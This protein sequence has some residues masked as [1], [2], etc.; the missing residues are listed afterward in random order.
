MTTEQLLRFLEER[1]SSGRKIVLTNG[2]FDLLHA[3]HASYLEEAKGLGDFL[4]VGVNSDRSVRELKKEGAPAV[5]EQHRA[6]L[7]GALGCVD[8]VVIFDEAT[9]V[10]LIK[11]VRPDVYVKGGDYTIDTINQEERRA[12][13]GI[14]AKVMILARVPSVSSTTLR[15]TARQERKALL[16]RIKQAAYL[17]GDFI[18]SSGKKSRYYLDKYLLETDPVLLEDIA[19]SMARM[20]P[21]AADRLAGV[22][23][24]GVALAAAVSLKT[25][26]PFVI[27]RRQAKEHGTGREFE[28]RLEPGDRVALVEDVVTTGRQAV[29]AVRRLENAGAKVTAVL[30][31]VD[32]Q[33][34]A[35]EAMS[36][37]GCDFRPLCTAAELGITT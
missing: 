1:R 7:L 14:G 8:A 18:L 33:E 26:I 13:E 20:L 37:A 28:G 34:G 22:E 11:A 10:E 36:Q 30:C 19:T 9:A 2:C 5:P 35:A 32:R 17:E 24:G 12:A 6:Q 29:Q 3:G 15:E 31:I 4:V 27:V 23:L 16:A 25:G 21:E